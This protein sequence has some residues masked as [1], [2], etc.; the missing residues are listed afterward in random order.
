M[1]DANY[2]TA[3]FLEPGNPMSAKKDLCG[4]NIVVELDKQHTKP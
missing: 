1:K 4:P 3:R 2:C